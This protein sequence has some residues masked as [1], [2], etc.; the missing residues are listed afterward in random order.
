MNE[1][2]FYSKYKFHSIDKIVKIVFMKKIIFFKLK[3]QIMNISI[4]FKFCATIV[5]AM[6]VKKKKKKKKNINKK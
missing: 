3:N 2:Y 1:I 6:L 5:L 4:F